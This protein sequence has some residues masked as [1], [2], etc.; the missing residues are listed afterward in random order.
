MKANEGRIGYVRIAKPGE[1][2]TAT[3]LNVIEYEGNCNPVPFT[4]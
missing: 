4:C 2:R 3:E 1:V